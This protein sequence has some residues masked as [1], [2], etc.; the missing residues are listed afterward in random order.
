MLAPTLSLT[1]A[2]SQ[3][4]HVHMSEPAERLTYEALAKHQL[5][6]DKQ[7][8]E[9]AKTYQL[10]TEP[11]PGRGY[12]DRLTLRLGLCRSTILAELHLWRDFAG[13]RGGLRHVSAG[14]KYVVS[15]QAVREYLTDL[16]A[17]A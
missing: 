15:E 11:T 4:L 6:L 1:L 13:K 16:K 2:S 17:A 8:A 10:G 3:V 5:A 9:L 12:D 14:K 7:A